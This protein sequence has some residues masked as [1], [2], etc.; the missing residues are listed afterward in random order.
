[1]PASFYRYDGDSLMLHVRVQPGARSTEIVG[2]LNGELRIRLS[3]RAT[4]G[5]ANDALQKFLA[6]QLGTA[7]SRVQIIR[8]ATS[9]SKTVAILGA[10]HTPESL[11]DG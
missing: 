3:A 6:K 5:Q 7:A 11:T 1:M 4:D 10:R 8:G 2:V 9:R